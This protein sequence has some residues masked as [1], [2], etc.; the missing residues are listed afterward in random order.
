VYDVAGRLIRTLADGA[1]T[2]GRHPSVW[3]GTDERG[4]HVAAGVYFARL[5]AG[6]IHEQRSVIVLR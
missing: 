6:A 5:D 4:K 3:D 1:F 2:A